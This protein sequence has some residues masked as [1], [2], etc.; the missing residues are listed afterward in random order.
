[1]SKDRLSR[2]SHSLA[3]LRE[4]LLD[5]F[6]RQGEG[7]PLGEVEDCSPSP[8]RPTSRPARTRSSAR[9]SSGRVESHDGDSRMDFDTN[10]YSDEELHAEFD[11]LFPQGFAG[12]DVLQELAPG[13]WENS[14][15]L[16]VFHPSVD[17]VY[18]ES[19]RMHRNLGELRRPDDRRP[20]P[21][22]PTRD[23]IARDFGSIPS[24]P[25]R[26][27]ASWSASASGMCS[28]TAMRWSRGGWPRARPRLVPVQRRLSGGRR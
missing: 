19:L 15:L 3:Q 6:F 23:E 4:H 8:T 14:P 27:S 28:P 9:E 17:Q 26:K 22:E 11:R 25:R 7:F 24:R 20:V 5:P 18:E 16:A 21:P 2:C 12:P 13:G 1:M 10:S